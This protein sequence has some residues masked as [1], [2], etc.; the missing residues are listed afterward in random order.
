MK[1]PYFVVAV[2]FTLIITKKKDQKKEMINLK[3]I[4]FHQ[5]LKI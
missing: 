4:Y 5:Y 2:F 1:K 3:N